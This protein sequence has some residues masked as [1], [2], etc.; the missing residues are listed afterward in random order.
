M[1]TSRPWP[2]RDFASKGSVLARCLFLTFLFRKYLFLVK[3]PGR[4]AS[5]GFPP[6][7]SRMA[8]GDLPRTVCVC[9]CVRAGV[10]PSIISLFKKKISGAFSAESAFALLI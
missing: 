1:G 4:R 8:R 5:C 7:F 6:G 10:C 2:Q 9:V 3:V